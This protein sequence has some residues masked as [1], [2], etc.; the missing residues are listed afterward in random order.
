MALSLQTS[1]GNEC[2]KKFN[3]LKKMS[4]RSQKLCG[5]KAHHS[6]LFA[7]VES[8]STCSLSYKFISQFDRGESQHRT[9]YNRLMWFKPLMCFWAELLTYC[10]KIPE[11]YYRAVKFEKLQHIVYGRKWGLTAQKFSQL[12]NL[13]L[14]KSANK[15]PCIFGAFLGY[16]PII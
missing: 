8:G 11:T 5:A 15:T 2:N 4:S 12:T 3:S 13:Y 16:C 6:T 14:K 10:H 9:L 1:T 7:A